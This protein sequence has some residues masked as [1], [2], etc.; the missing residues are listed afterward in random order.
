[1]CVVD[2]SE[3][4]S[5]MP[6][7][8]L[9]SPRRTGVAGAEFRVHDTDGTDRLAGRTVVWPVQCHLHAVSVPE[10]SHRS[11]HLRGRLLKRPV[12]VGLIDH[13]PRTCIE[14]VPAVRYGKPRRI[15]KQDRVGCFCCLRW[16]IQCR[17][18]RGNWGI[19]VYCI[20]G[21]RQLATTD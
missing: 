5:E 4:W 1:M 3:I 12:R 20:I 14:K 2:C 7:P 11:R 9:M 18:I 15:G 6:M 10:T 17:R 16:R 13:S 8:V 19:A 21:T